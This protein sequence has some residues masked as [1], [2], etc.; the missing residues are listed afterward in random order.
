MRRPIHPFQLYRKQGIQYFSLPGDDTFRPADKTKS[1]FEHIGM[2]LMA[3]QHIYTPPYQHARK[4]S[5][6]T[7]T[8]ILPAGIAARE[9]EQVILEPFMNND[10][11]AISWFV[12]EFYHSGV[13]IRKTNSTYTIEWL[14]DD[15]IIY[16][17][18]GKEVSLYDNPT[19]VEYR[20]DLHKNALTHKFD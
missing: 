7:I 2:H 15:L 19:D 11:A 5:P 1:P 18:D 20:I 10:E 3:N 6:H 13:L 14:K 9:T 12:R 16:I 17:R 8:I 4:S